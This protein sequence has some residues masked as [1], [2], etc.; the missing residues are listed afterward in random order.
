MKPFPAVNLLLNFRTQFYLEII[1]DAVKSYRNI[2]SEEQVVS[3]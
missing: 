1:A 2:E 3:Q